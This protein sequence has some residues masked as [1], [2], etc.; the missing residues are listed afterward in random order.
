MEG[1]RNRGSLKMMVGVLALA[2][3]GVGVSANVEGLKAPSLELPSVGPTVV[4]A[5]TPT[6]PGTGPVANTATPPSANTPTAKTA[7]AAPTGTHEPSAEP[8]TVTTKPAEPVAAAIEHAPIRAKSEESGDSAAAAKSPTSGMTGSFM[9]IV[10]VGG[11]LGI[12]V[13]IILIGRAMMK[14]FVPGAA[15]GNGKGVLET[16]ARY[17][18]GRNQSVV[19]LRIGSQIVA[20]N[21][22]KETSQSIMVISE[23]MEVAKIIGQ[24]AGQD[25]NSIQTNFNRALSNA[26]MDLESTEEVEETDVLESRAEAAGGDEDLDQQLEEMAAA[27]RQLMELRAQ[28]RNV[29]DN[30]PA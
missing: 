17:P 15:V 2:V 20:L 23:P 4:A 13:G 10:Q 9:S 14:R 11:A 24:I 7:D 27:K 5:V 18:I 8:P 6:T 25:T 22:T 1:R 28:V 3:S 29:R 19:L 26:R 21:Q 30:L 16:L 12:V